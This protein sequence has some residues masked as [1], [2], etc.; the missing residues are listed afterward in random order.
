M[1]KYLREWSHFLNGGKKFKVHIRFNY[2]QDKD[3][4]TSV[5]RG[6]LLRRVPN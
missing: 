1:D 5:D 3:R 2:V 4:V 6:Q